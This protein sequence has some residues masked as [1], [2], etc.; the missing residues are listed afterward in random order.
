MACIFF[1]LS[2]HF[3]I[4]QSDSISIDTIAISEKNL[5]NTSPTTFTKIKNVPNGTSLSLDKGLNAQSSAFI[6][7]YGAG[8]ISTISLRGGSS[9]Q[10]LVKWQNI[11]ITNP[12]L[13]L[14]DFSLIP[15]YNFNA[16]TLNIGGSSVTNGSGAMTGV[17]EL[18]NNPV[19]KEKI[20]TDVNLNYGSFN[21]KSLGTNFAFYKNKWAF[22]TT[23]FTTSADNDFKYKTSNGETKSQRHAFGK[24]RA[25]TTS[26]YYFY[27]QNSFL[28]LDAWLQNTF[29]QIPPT[30]TQNNSASDLTD[31]LYRY[32]LSYQFTNDIF[33]FKSQIA[34]LNEHN[35]FRDSLNLI[36]TDNNFDKLIHTS[37][38]TV[39]FKNHVLQSGYSTDYI[40][41]KTDFYESNSTIK[42][43]GL[44]TN[45]NLNF[46]DHHI[47][48]GLRKD[49]QSTST[50]PL[51]PEI[52]YSINLSQKQSLFTKISHEFRAPTSNELFWAPGGNENLTPETAW[53]KEL[54]YSYAVSNKT[55]FNLG[56]FH[57]VTKNWILWTLNPTLNYFEATNIAQVN[58]Y[59]LDVKHSYQFSTASHLTHKIIANYAYTISKNEKDI[60]IPL[61]KKG[62][63]L[64]Y[65]PKH[66]LSL[67][68]TF[69]LSDYIFA[70]DA[71]YTSSTIGIQDV[72]PSYWLTDVSFK[73]PIS[74][75][76]NKIQLELSILNLLNNNYR[77][78][79]KRPMPGRHF[80]LGIHLKL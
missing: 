17:I 65:T 4:A 51:S 40:N 78:I 43:L 48:M 26:A 22:K 77:V 25:L 20:S 29:R 37:T 21:K 79:E 80:E 38:I 6:K 61:I 32:N 54:A 5:F 39:N 9:T 12:M 74:F 56:L 24:N 44:F 19:F 2:S 68:Y 18:K 14:N 47:K 60:A 16:I 59:G 58:S 49:W 23:F 46:N 31:D 67:N 66:K 27:S 1:F 34:Y 63:Q 62:T 42:T 69:N 45:L 76:K 33:S 15:M 41:A 64:F 52:S 71:I 35:K 7:S 28:Q 57:R 75:Y 10:T 73:A 72:I 13:G 70:L 3:C 50:L 36:F 8:S 30:T 55:E 53:N 11:P